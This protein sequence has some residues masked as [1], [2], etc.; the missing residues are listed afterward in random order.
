MV[1]GRVRCVYGRVGEGRRSAAG[2]ESTAAVA[3]G[4]EGAAPRRSSGPVAYRS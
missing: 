4:L 3:V 1:V 2:A